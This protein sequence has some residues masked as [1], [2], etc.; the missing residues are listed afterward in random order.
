MYRAQGYNNA[1]AIS[2]N[3]RSVQAILK[4]KN[5][6]AIFNGSMGYLLNMCGKHYFA[7]NASCVTFFGTLER[8]YSSLLLSPINEIF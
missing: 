6:K 1:A 4:R 7:E 2:E 8:M 5:Y 3:H